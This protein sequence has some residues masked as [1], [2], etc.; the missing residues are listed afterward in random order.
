MTGNLAGVRPAVTAADV[1]TAVRTW[2]LEQNPSLIVASRIPNP[3]PSTFVRIIRTGG[4]MAGV[5]DGA[6]IVVEAWAETDPDADRL[7]QEVRTLI[8][9]AAG[10]RIADTW[11]VYR[12]VELSGP[13]SLPDPDSRQSRVTLTVQVDV[14]AV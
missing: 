13:G 4:V 12:V 7:A 6:V 14:R 5:V 2:L 8:G 9:S 3:R 11:T 10:R 1:V